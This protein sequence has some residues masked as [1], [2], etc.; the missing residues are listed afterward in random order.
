MARYTVGNTHAGTQQ[1]L[2]TS[3]KTQV[4]LTS[5][6]ANLRRAWIYEAVFGADGTPADVSIQYKI[7]RQTTVGTGTAATPSPHDSADLAAT[8]VATVCHTAEPTITSATQLMLASVNCR[9]TYRWVAAP[10]SELVVPATNVAG[11]G[12][13]AKSPSYTSTVM[14]H[15]HFWE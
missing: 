3:Y 12:A 10:G 2:T 14:A 11:L 15:L 9:A 5:A 7:D 8:I 13:R 1:N 6:T 4:S